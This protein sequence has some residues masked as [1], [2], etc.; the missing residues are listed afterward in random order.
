V[1]VA[2]ALRYRAGGKVVHV[3][4]GEYGDGGVEQRHVDVLAFAGDIAVGER[5][6]DCDGAVHAG[7][8]IGDGDAHFLRAAAGQVIALAGD[9]HQAAHAL[10]HEVVA[11]AVGVRPALAEAGDRTVDDAGA[12]RL[13]V[14]V[15]EAVAR[16]RADLVVFDHDVRLRGKPLHDRLAFG[17][18]D[19]ERDRA[20]AAIAGKV[21]GGLAGVDPGFILEKRRAPAAGVV[22]GA[23]ALHL[24]H[25]G[26]HVGEVLGAPW[27]GEDPRQIEDPD[28]R[29]HF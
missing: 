2:V 28:V 27:T 16:E 25:V 14:V 1:R 21:I 29:Q 26:P 19:V 24:D 8:D 9:A 12:H 13:Q 18:G 5:A 20:L 17:G 15:G 23:R 7:E 10:E 6:E 22:A 3:L 4:V 11:G